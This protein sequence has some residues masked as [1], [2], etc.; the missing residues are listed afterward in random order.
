M[1]IW[2]IRRYEPEMAAMWNALVAESRNGT[3][4]LDRRFM[5]YHADR[6]ADCSLVALRD[7]RPVAVLPANLTDDG[8]LHSHSGLTY[9]GWLT[10][11]RH[12][13]G[14]DMLDLFE[15]W[16]KWGRETGLK[17]F[18]YKPIP[19]IYCDLPSGE[20]EYALWRYSAQLTSVNL[21]S[22]FELADRPPFE[23]RQKRNLKKAE[24]SGILTIRK[25]H[26]AERFID[27]VNACLTE[28]HNATA[29]HSGAELSSL[30]TAFPNNIDLWVAEDLS[31]PNTG[32]FA[33]VCIF[34]TGRVAHAQY[35][36]TSPEG[37]ENGSL[38]YLFNHLISSYR[39][40]KW[41]DYGTSNEDNGRYLNATLLLQKTELGGRGVPYP[42]F[43]LPLQ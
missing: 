5:D 16:T 27:F 21:S 11:C 28:R 43:T 4:L 38:A 40:A 3:F 34:N 37:R 42:R 18:D 36:A 15:A 7:G 24:K 2:E 22:A 41:F 29:V 17:A 35:I 19:Y 26:D 12:F 9:G 39:E 14:S 8:I 30:M 10:P 13:D 1:G 33:G 31:Q 6:F 32:W 25:T 23:K 20:D